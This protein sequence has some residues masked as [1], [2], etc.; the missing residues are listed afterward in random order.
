MNKFSF[1][2]GL[3]GYG[4]FGTD[5]SSGLNGFSFYTS[6][7]SGVNNQ[8]A[9]T[10]KIIANQDLYNIIS[11]P[12]LRPYQTGD[13]F[14]DNNSTIWKINLSTGFK[15]E[16][17]NI[18]LGSGNIFNKLTI[19]DGIIS[20][21]RYS[22]NQTVGNQKAIDFVFTGDNTQANYVQ[23]NNNVY[24]IS[25][26]KFGQII[27]NS[28][29]CPN[30]SSEY[31]R[32]FT[33]WNNGI[34]DPIGQIGLICDS[35]SVW[36]IGNA[37]SLTSI[38]LVNS[39]LEFD[40]ET[41][42]KNKEG[43][44]YELLS[45]Y[46]IEASPLFDG[47]LNVDSSYLN[48]SR[49][50]TTLSI[51]WD[52]THILNTDVVSNIYGKLVVYKKDVATTFTSPSSADVL[53]LEDIDSNGVITVNGVDP[54]FTYGAYIE[55][56]YNG[57]S[58]KTNPKIAELLY[59]TLTPNTLSNFIAAGQTK[60]VYLTSNVTWSANSTS[61][62]TITPNSGGITTSPLL[63]NI[64]A[65]AQTDATTGRT[66]PIVFTGAGGSVTSTL[67]ITQDAS[68][69]GADSVT[70]SANTVN[71]TYQ[72]AATPLIFN[73]ISNTNW[74]LTKP[75]WVNVDITSGA[76]GTTLVTVSAISN[77]VTNILTGNI[78]I[79]AG[80]ASATVYCQQAA[81]V[82]SQVGVLRVVDDLGGIMPADPPYPT[83]D[84][85]TGAWNFTVYNLSTT[86]TLT[87]NNI[88]KSSYEPP[89]RLIVGG[90][91]LYAPYSGTIAP[92]ASLACSIRYNGP[93]GGYAQTSV[94]VNTSAGDRIFT[95][96]KNS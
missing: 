17:A 64:T 81:Y 67:S 86:E 62:L 79:T 70:T 75:S 4:T 22:N 73:V 11:T 42:S 37:N 35:N 6:D 74:T 55:F 39:K 78:S 12:S 94:W 72:G 21:D 32:P 85:Y 90:A 87:I 26:L 91:I 49:N 16:A 66:F 44:S 93:G 38:P 53:V 30:T 80:T 82:S 88:Y 40:F 71:F 43:R 63:I 1:S 89:F 60:S 56:T 84:V 2:S 36:H 27:F 19:A 61:W 65:A 5:G 92:G 34:T 31:L 54:G 28:Y 24:G 7:L 29:L 77:G 20:F 18:Q 8:S 25:P 59:L 76:A 47:K 3:P 96:V 14:V 41:V 23:N 48:I 68:V 69:S 52:K 33:I 13:T 58:R 51:S 46:E 9:L 57:W 15:Y 45:K 50:S 83:Y 10:A 95:I